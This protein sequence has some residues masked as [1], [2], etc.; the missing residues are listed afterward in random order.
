MPSKR[1][2]PVLRTVK[3]EN[4]ISDLRFSRLLRENEHG[5]GIPSP[6]AL[7]EPPTSPRSICHEDP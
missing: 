5:V 6:G 4:S 3:I 2:S 1:L 7:L